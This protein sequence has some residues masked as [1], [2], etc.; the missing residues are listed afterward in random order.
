MS[1]WERVVGAEVVMADG[2]RH[3]SP[4]SLDSQ[5]TVGPVAVAV[6]Q[7]LTMDDGGET[8]AWTAGPLR[9]KVDVGAIRLS[10]HLDH[11]GGGAPVRIFKHGHQSWSWSGAVVLGDHE[12]PARR[13]AP[14]LVRAIYEADPEPADAGEVRSEGA[15]VIDLGDRRLCLGALGGDAHDTT[16]RIRARPGGLE[17]LVEAYLGGA[18]LGAERPLHV[19]GAWEGDQP[20][21]LL[22]TWAAGLGELERA[23]VDAPHQVGWCSWYHWFDRITETD[24]AATVARSETWPFDVIQVDDGWQ[25]AIGDWRT[26]SAS[27]PSGLVALAERITGAG[28]QP[29]LWLAPFLVAPSSNLA[30]EH[31]QWIARWIDG[32]EPLVG[33]VNPTWGGAV[34]V[35]DPTHPEVVA[36]LEALAS[37]LATAGFRYLKLDFCYAPSLP[38]RYHDRQ[39][40]PAER[41][42]AGLA[43]IRRGAGDSVFL[44]GCGAPLV[45]SVGL[46]DGMRIGPDVAPSWRPASSTRQFPGYERTVPATAHAWDATFL[47]SWMHRLLWLNDPDCL[48]LRRKDTELDRVTADAWAGAVAYSGGTVMVSDD[49]ALLGSGAR[50]R[51]EGVVKV[52]REVDAAARSG[53]PPRCGELL[54]DSPPATLGTPGWRIVAHVTERGAQILS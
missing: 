13:G 23:R 18:R 4:L 37:D 1:F 52:S 16:F 34:H 35:L 38:G 6:G 54:D 9:Q 5:A 19:V 17:I 36:H 53:Y 22:A 12:D 46:V 32:R 21:A 2:S 47:R 31:P 10:V 26:T 43:A 51:L 3:V 20:Y 41:V 45:P 44:L 14:W 50:R 11:D 8:V 33:N 27:F 15:V 28:R 39:A 29:G 25:S 24:V 42:R 49:L 48:M 40:T 7:P 30:R